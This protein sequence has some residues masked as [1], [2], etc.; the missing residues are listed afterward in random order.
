MLVSYILTLNIACKLEALKEEIPVLVYRITYL[1]E[2]YNLEEYYNFID[3]QRVLD[4]DYM[5]EF[6]EAIIAEKE[7]IAAEREEEAKADA[8]EEE[9]IQEGGVPQES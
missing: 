1:A 6:K 3:D 7:A 8:Q 2:R 9:I 4:T 5:K